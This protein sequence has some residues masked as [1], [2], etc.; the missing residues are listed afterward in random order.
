MVGG[1][2]KEEACSLGTP[3]GPKMV[4][5]QPPEIDPTIN[6]HFHIVHFELK[7]MSTELIV[8]MCARFSE[9]YS[10]AVLC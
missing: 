8:P 10:V 6:T 9:Q 4:W 1:L 7:L 5:P 2:W 3:K